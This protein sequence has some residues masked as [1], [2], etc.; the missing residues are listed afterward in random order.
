MN[1]IDLHRTAH[2]YIDM[3][4]KDAVYEAATM[5][6]KMSE[7]GD[8]AGVKVWKRIMEIIE[9]WQKVDGEKVH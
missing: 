4:G 8:I 2:L 5:A 1:P 3:H 7:Q 6:D 9:Q